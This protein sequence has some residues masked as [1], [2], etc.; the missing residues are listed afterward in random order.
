MLIIREW[1]V[2]G[3]GGAGRGVQTSVA[4]QGA[5]R[6]SRAAPRRRQTNPC[7]AAGAARRRLR[8]RQVKRY[9]IQLSLASV[10]ATVTAAAAA[11]AASPWRLTVVV[12]APR[13]AAHAQ[14]QACR[15]A[16]R[17][18]RG[19]AER[20]R[21]SCCADTRNIENRLK[22][23]RSMSCGASLRPPRLAAPPPRPPRGNTPSGT[24]QCGGGGGDGDGVS[25]R[26]R[27]TAGPRRSRRVAGGGV[28]V[29]AA[30][31]GGRAAG[32]RRRCLLSSPLLAA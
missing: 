8:P 10:A 24:P 14:R 21:V 7:R 1:G 25:N 5:R 23:G 11:A 12:V 4:A 16:R 30:G 29:R 19:L 15:R 13:R 3:R 28:C 17:G 27:V 9:K 20:P 6:Q 18:G 2:P 32:W 31:R 26:P 22:I